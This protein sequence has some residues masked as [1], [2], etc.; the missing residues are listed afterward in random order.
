MIIYTRSIYQ[1]IS[2]GERY[3]SP[4]ISVFQI[5]LRGK[6]ENT[7]CRGI[8]NFAGRIF[9][10]EWWESDK[11]WFCIFEPF[12]K[13]KSRFCK[14]WTP[15][16]IKISMT[17]MYKDYKFEIKIVQEQLLQQKWSLYGV[18]IWK[19]L[20]RGRDEPLMRWDKNLVGGGY[21][22]SLLLF[23]ICM[24]KTVYKHCFI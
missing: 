3:I 14:Y 5:V 9:F 22:K 13:L 20:S 6:Q 4:I 8:G 23:C 15:T 12:S 1:N 24:G 19:L 10:I 11:E 17:C 16:E 18:L 21:C 2:F 7:L